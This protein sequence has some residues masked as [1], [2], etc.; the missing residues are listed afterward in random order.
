LNTPGLEHLASKETPSTLQIADLNNYQISRRDERL[1]GA[2]EDTPPRVRTRTRN[3]TVSCR[4][5]RSLMTNNVMILLPPLPSCCDHTWEA[6][7]VCR[8]GTRQHVRQSVAHRGRRR[9]RVQARSIAYDDTGCCESRRAC[10]LRRCRVL[11]P[12]GRLEGAFE[13]KF[14]V[15]SAGVGGSGPLRHQVVVVAPER[16]QKGSRCRLR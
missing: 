15:W 5:C 11:I 8:I 14:S 9:N 10:R 12:G 2:E 16:S 3:S 4:V 7:K 6:T 1:A 13:R